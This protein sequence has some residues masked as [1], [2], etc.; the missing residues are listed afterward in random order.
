MVRSYKRIPTLLALLDQLLAQD[1]PSYEI[2]VVEQTVEVAPEHAARLAELERDPRLRVLR[3]P[4]L[5]GARARNVG[6]EAARGEILLF[7]DDD[8]APHGTGWIAAH[9]AC[10]DDPAC[11]GVNGRHV[12]HPDERPPY[13]DL[14]RAAR[15]CQRFSPVLRLPWTY[16]RIDQ[17]VRPV[18]AIHGTNGSIRRVAFE[19]F[20]GWDTDTRIEDEASFGF[21]AARGMRP[22]EYFCF[23][24]R[25]LVVR[26]QDVGE[27]LAKRFMTPGQYFDRF[28]E[29]ALRIVGRYHP[30]RIRALFPL[31][32]VAVWIRTIDWML[33]D[34]RARFT[35]PRAIGAAAWLGVTAP[36]RAVRVLLRT[37]FGA[38]TDSGTGSPARSPAPAPRSASS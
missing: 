13:R 4:P 18:D 37:G 25:P 23:D 7:I 26:G 2:V 28:F 15:R 32:V 24:P 12:H 8:D 17:P 36:V 10:Y 6:A 27:G 34:A 11:L 38:P 21:R 9:V 19:R 3:H 20:G 33:D 29:F 5:G 35:V 30:A 16:V 22:G 31:Y 1:H 14:A